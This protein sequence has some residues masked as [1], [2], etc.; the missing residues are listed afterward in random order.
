[1][2]KFLFI[3]I[4]G[5]VIAK[6]IL[7]PIL[8][9]VLVKSAGKMMQDMQ[10]RQQGRPVNPGKAADPIPPKKTNKEVPGEYID[11]EEVK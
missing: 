2:I 6:Y 11:Y 9:A 8:L 3:L 5:Y 4:I 7:R 1:M 10:N